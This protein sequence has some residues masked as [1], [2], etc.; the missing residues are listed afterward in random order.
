M[1]G[2]NLD[3]TKKN[4]SGRKRSLDQDKTPM[5]EIGNEENLET[6][7]LSICPG[8]A[9]AHMIPALGR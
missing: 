7:A 6:M 1:F 9:A 4:K 2:Q 8:V 5:K 3:Q